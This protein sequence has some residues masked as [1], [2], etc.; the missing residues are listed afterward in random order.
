VDLRAQSRGFATYRRGEVVGVAVETA[1]ALVFEAG[2]EGR[3][4]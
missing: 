3:R 2:G 4:L 1:R